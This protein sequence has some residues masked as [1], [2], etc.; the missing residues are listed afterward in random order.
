MNISNLVDGGDSFSG[1]CVCDDN[2]GVNSE[3]CSSVCDSG[4][5]NYRIVKDNNDERMQQTNF[6]HSCNYACT[7]NP[8]L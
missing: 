8:E 6:H 7:L 3:R 4:G 5:C 2:G 1:S